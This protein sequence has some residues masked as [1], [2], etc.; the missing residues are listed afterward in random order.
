MKKLIAAMTALMI[1]VCGCTAAFA[2]VNSVTKEEAMKIALDHFGMQKNQV[3][4]TEIEKDRDDGRLVWE[5]EF[6]RGGIKYEADVDVR[7]GRIT[8]AKAHR[9]HHDD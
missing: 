8:E 1:L 9:Y 4:F 7:T 2:D 5:I 6:I 3:T